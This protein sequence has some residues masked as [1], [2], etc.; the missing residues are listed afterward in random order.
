MTGTHPDSGPGKDGPEP[1][2]AWAAA[3]PPEARDFQGHRAGFVTRLVAVG[4]DFVLVAVA[5]GAVYVGWAVALF[6]LRPTD[7]TLPT[8]AFGLV[9]LAG[10]FLAWVS[11][12]T[13]WASTG[14]TIGARVMG[15]RVVGRSG[16]VMRLPGAALRA[17]FCLAFMPGLVWVIVS[18]QNRS[19]QDTLLRT[20]VIY[21]WTKR[22][23]S[24]SAARHT[25][26]EAPSP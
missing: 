23:P 21:D 7:F 14:R 20:S 9:L 2:P 25:R 12:T 4:I 6:A 3:V 18:H 24:R 11:F 13:A 26:G 10:F 8:V 16:N 15:I 1:L 22:A 17:A 5:L 19:L